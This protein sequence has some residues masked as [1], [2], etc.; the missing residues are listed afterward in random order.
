VT[1]TARIGIGVVV[2]LG[3]FVFFL[4]TV[5]SL[6]EPQPGVSRIPV[7]EVLAQADP[8]DAY[9]T[10]E[11]HVSGWYAELDA[12]CRTPAGSPGPGSGPGPAWLEASCPLRVLLPYQPDEDVTQAELEAAGLRLAAPT[13]SAFPAR[14]RPDGPNLRLQQLVYVGHFADPAAEGCA[15]AARDRCRSTFV[16]SDYDGVL[17]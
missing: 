5:G 6:G 17:R 11:L 15:P 3:A 14:A 1:R 4:L 2:L 12:D 9:G 7:A 16:V 8:A 10:R 13:G